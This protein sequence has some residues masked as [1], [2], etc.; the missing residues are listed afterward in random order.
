MNDQINK[1]FDFAQEIAKQLIS[2]ATAVITVTLTFSH[3]FATHATGWIRELVPCSWGL[4]LFSIVAGIW[5][6][7]ALTGNLQ[8]LGPNSQPPSIRTR[9]VTFPAIVQIL[10]F[11][12]GMLL[13]ILFGALAA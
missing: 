6:L 3:D 8:Q 4:L 12:F 10:S 9:N 11:L 1:A 5:T 7:M 2:L 13:V